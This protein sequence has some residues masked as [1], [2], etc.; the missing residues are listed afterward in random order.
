MSQVISSV[1]EA[2][3]FSTSLPP[4]LEPIEARSPLDAKGAL[5]KSNDSPPSRTRASINVEALVASMEAQLLASAL[6]DKAPLRD[7]LPTL[8]APELKRQARLRRIRHAEQAIKERLERHGLQRYRQRVID[9][10]GEPIL[11]WLYFR[12]TECLLADAIDENHPVLLA[13]TAEPHRFIR[14]LIS[15]YGGSRKLRPIFLWTSASGLYEIEGEGRD[16]VFHP[17]AKAQRQIEQW[18]VR[19]VKLSSLIKKED[20]GPE[21]L[22]SI[23]QTLTMSSERAWGIE[24]GGRTTKIWLNVAD[25][26]DNGHEIHLLIDDLS[27]EDEEFIEPDEGQA[28][29]LEHEARKAVLRK[30][31]GR[32]ADQA[33]EFQTLNFSAVISFL[34]S[35]PV[36]DAIVILCDGH[37]HL[38]REMGPAAAVNARVV[39]DAFYRLRRMR[40]G[41]KLVLFA[42]DA[43][44]PTDLRE[45]L[46]RTDLPLPSRAEVEFSLKERIANAGLPGSLLEVGPGSHFTRLVDAAV[47]MT[48]GEVRTVLDRFASGAERHLANLVSAMHDAKKRSVARSPALE[49]VDLHGSELELGGMERLVRWL[50][51]RHAVFDRPD[52]AQAAGIDRRPKGVLLLGI[53]GTGKS[54]AA[55]VVAKTWKLPLLRLDLG[56]IQDKWV[57]SSEARIR[58]ALKTVVAMSPCVLWIDEIDKG[59]AQGPGTG[60]HSTDL[61][62]RATLLTWMQEYSQPVFIVA[63]ANRISHLPPE[64]MRAGRFDARFFLG[65]PGAQGR[66]EILTMHLQRRRIDPES[67]DMSTLVNGTHGYT[68]AEIEQ[69]V[70]DALYDAFHEDERSRPS[71]RHFEQ[72]LADSKPL[73]KTI[74]TQDDDTGPRGKGALDE[75]W[76]L[77]DQGRVELASDDLLTRAQ[78]AQLIDPFLYRPVYCR[79]ET[80]SGFE[81]LQSK[82]ERIAMGV[83]H[84][85][86]VAVV[87]DAGDGWVFVYTNVQ[88]DRLDAHNFKFIDRFGTIEDNGVFDT[89]VV[90]HGLE[91]VLFLEA[92]M[93]ER[94]EKSPSL[95]QISDLFEM[96]SE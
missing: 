65:C 31:S 52:A 3:S 75:V 12:P 34:L 14:F 57:G 82:G 38:A 21:N 19:F 53:P 74:G 26:D 69:L 10:E 58:E 6:D 29:F 45:E 84:G 79:K 64:L 2:T 8:L 43:D 22:G 92:D 54:L 5:S 40:N 25:A 4:A 70:L 77:I 32:L 67:L 71:M 39:K 33:K 1:P 35:Q 46:Q 91:L 7:L 85:G 24:L 51:A 66:K 47:G 94:F 20:R 50:K 68:G 63:T 76:D 37:H 90:Q 60:S 16:A 86:V 44:F 13:V 48:M 15:R 28:L 23:F 36:E 49:V 17:V 87:L 72:R 9:T 89:L 41:M 59:I 93:M 83:I 55:K 61:N 56:A 62:I 95:S 78:V 18:P 81:K 88:Y 80:V 11:A 42:A 96:A 27:S 30:M 73:I